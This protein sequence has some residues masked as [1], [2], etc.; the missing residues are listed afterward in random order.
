[1]IASLPFAPEIVLPTIAH[2]NRENLAGGHPHG[3]RAT[4]NPTYPDASDAAHGW[5]SPWHFGIN[6]GP[7][8]VMI[9]NHRS[10]FV[11]RLTRTSPP[12]VAGLRAAGFSGAWLASDG[13]HA[14]AASDV[15]ETPVTP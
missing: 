4:F 9:E 8:V 3:F 11:W 6:M 2:F 12:I 5:V 1:V 14:R 7:I 15:L 10:G 13:G